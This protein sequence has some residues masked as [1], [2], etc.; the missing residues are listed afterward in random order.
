MKGLEAAAKQDFNKEPSKE[1]A[2]PSEVDKAFADQDAAAA[3]A[4]AAAKK[5]DAPATTTPEIKLT[6]TP[7]KPADDFLEHELTEDI[8][9]PQKRAEWDKFRENRNKILRERDDVRRQLDE[10]KQKVVAPDE[11]EAL[12]KERDDLAARYKEAA[13][14]ND[15]QLTADIDSRFNAVVQLA[16]AS[17]PDPAKAENLEAILRMQAG[18]YRDKALDEFFADMPGH[19]Q[20]LIASHIASA[21]QLSFERSSRL[22]AAKANA[23]AILKQ[24]Q[25][26]A[27]AQRAARAQ[28]VE[29]VF[30]DVTNEFKSREG[31]KDIMGHAD[32]AR[33]IEQEARQTFSGGVQDEAELGRKAYHAAMAPVVMKLALE[34]AKRLQ[35]YEG[36]IA[37]LKASSPSVNT[38]GTTNAGVGRGDDFLSNDALAK[39]IG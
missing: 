30:T 27:D 4:A 13:V 36:T 21:D 14:V 28:H 6:V 11:I 38:I 8:K 3:T 19:K 33:A 2:K 18:Q 29:K 34:Q 22:Q 1:P 39:L 10:L 20:A 35:E 24:R 37:K 15:P 17:L 5:P 32:I 25:Q 26:Q 16:K 12:R 23:D 9:V 7:D 31:W